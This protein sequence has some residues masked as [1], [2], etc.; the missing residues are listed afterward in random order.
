MN[1]DD[2]QKPENTPKVEIA[3]SVRNF[4]PIAEA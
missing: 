4:G 2:K 1:G 3:I